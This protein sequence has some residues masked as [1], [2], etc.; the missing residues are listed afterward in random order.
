MRERAR[1][2]CEKR[3]GVCVDSRRKVVVRRK[4]GAERRVEWSQEK[5]EE[6]RGASCRRAALAEVRFG[7]A[8]AR[9]ACDQSKRPSF[10]S[11]FLSVSLP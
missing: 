9:L 1:Y 6:A 8:P 10:P 7:A 3:R 5:R 2:G 11:R 4:C